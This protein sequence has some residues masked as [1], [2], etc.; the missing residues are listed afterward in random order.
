MRRLP[1][2]LL[3]FLTTLSFGESPWQTLGSRV[4]QKKLSNGITVLVLER[5]YAPTISI[6]MLFPT[7]S[8]DETSGKTGLA[9]MFEH[10]LFKGTKKLG[11]RQYEEEAPLLKEIDRLYQ[12]LDVEKSKRHLANQQKIAT[13]LETVRP[14]EKKAAGYV[15]E[16]ELW[17]IY[18]REGGSNLNASTSR[19]YTQYRVD[20]PSNKLELWAM[21]DSD[22][23]KNPVFR[24]F[25]A[26]RE[27]V[28]EERRMRVDN[29]PD[30]KLFEQFLATAY[31]AHPYRNPTIGWEADIDRLHVADLEDFYKRYYTPD[32]LTIAVVG[33]VQAADVFGL[34]ERYFGSWRTAPSQPARITDEP[35]Q[36]GE[37]LLVLKDE[38]QP[39]LVVGYPL[40][41]YPDRNHFVS[42]ALTNLLTEG[43]SS[44]LYKALVEK[45]QLAVSIDSFKDYPGNRFA[46]LLII[47]AVPRFPVTNDKL[48]AAL[49]EE[50][51]R[52]KEK[53]IERW[54][55]EKVRASIEMQMLG[56]LQS[57]G[58]MADTLAYSQA[59]FGDW[60]Y[61]LEYAKTMPTVTAEDI[62]KLAKSALTVDKRL[63]GMLEPKR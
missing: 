44:R 5:H 32:R 43:L 11:T 10:M 31:L 46:P 6:R 24:Q 60:K 20:L 56:L 40:T 54:E 61:L 13:L 19:D 29:D 27:V 34:A 57:N 28:K 63:V 36:T 8:V 41:A 45:K 37:R 51:D 3:F 16:N 22:R 49:Q 7:G 14:L 21:L 1:L 52:I 42:E 30:G 47:S 38:S 4:V 33:D 12:E 23:V 2:V 59:I 50:I 39:K 15:K 35:S 26:E 62:Q 17:Q 25:Y 58:G 9:H 48:L 18:E 53:P 55:M